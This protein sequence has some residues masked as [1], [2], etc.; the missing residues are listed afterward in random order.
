MIV[1]IL[2]VSLLAKL[3]RYKLKYLFYTWT[4][5][6]V[7]AIQLM[8]LIFQFSVFFGTDFFIRFVP[9]S[10]PAVILSFVFAIF[11]LRLYKPAVVGSVL[12]LA[13]TVLNKIVMASNGGKMPV[14][15]SLSY[16]TGYI[17]PDIAGPMD[18][19]HILGSSAV[20]YKFLADYIDFGYC[21]L[22]PGDVLIHLFA[23]IMLYFMIAAV[24]NRYNK[25]SMG[26]N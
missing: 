1:E 2:L 7:L 19:V 26:G 11:A 10:E 6:P 8:L 5:Y 24:N 16:L 12:V 14:F 17:K 20:N 23:C 18:S 21:I 13:G 3:K 4:F 22:S 15:P 9:I 25:Q